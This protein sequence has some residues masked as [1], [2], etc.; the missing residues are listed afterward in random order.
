MFDFD[1]RFTKGAIAGAAQSDFN[2]KN[3]KS[4][5]LPHDWSIEDL[6]NASD[7]DEKILNLSE[8]RWKFIRGDN[9]EYKK[10]GAFEGNWDIVQVPANWQRYPLPQADPNWGWFRRSVMLSEDDRGKNFSVQLGK[11]GD[12]DELYFNGQLVGSSGQMPPD[13]VSAAKEERIYLIPPSVI[14]YNGRNVLAIRVYSKSGKGGFLKSRPVRQISGPFDSYSEGGRH[15]AFTVGGVGWYR[16]TFHVSENEMQRA[17]R[18]KF[19]GVYKDANVWINGHRLKSHYNGYTPFEYNITEWIRPGEENV[20]AVR[21]DNSGLNS[22]W[23]SGS[24]IYRHVWLI[25]SEKLYHDD[26]Y[27]LIETVKADTAGSILNFSAGIKNNS[28][29]TTLLRWRVEI[30]DANGDQVMVQEK[31]VNVFVEGPHAFS[32]KLNIDDPVLWSPS[33][34]NLYTLRSSLFFGLKPMDGFETRFGI[35]SIEYSADKGLLMNGKPVLLKGGNI[36]HDNGALGAKAFNAAE[37]R[38]IKLLKE[39]GYNAVRTVHNPPSSALLNA[40]DELGMMVMEEAFDVWRVSKLP[41]DYHKVFDENWRSDVSSMVLRDRNHPSVII[42]SIGNDIP[43]RYDPGIETMTGLLKEEIHRHDTS[44]PV[45]AG[46]GLGDKEWT[47]SDNFFSV[48]DIAGYNYLK[49]KYQADN[50]RKPQRIIVGT[51]SYP[52]QAWEYWQSTVTHPFVIGDF[53]WSAFD[54]LGESGIGLYDNSV[55]PEDIYPAT[56]AYCGDFDLSG[57]LRPQGVYRKILWSKT[58]Q[59]ALYITNPK[60]TYGDLTKVDWAWEDVVPLWTWPGYEKLFF[61]AVVYTNCEEVKLF[62]NGREI[63]TKQVSPSMKN[64]V[65]FL[66]EYNPGTIVATGINDNETKVTSTIRTAEFPKAIILKPDRNEMVADGQ[67]LVYVD[68]EIH[69][70][71]GNL[72]PNYTIPLNFKLLG[73]GEIVGIGNGNPQ[74]TESFQGPVKSTYNGRC[75]VII[76]SKQVAG[77]IQLNVADVGKLVPGSVAIKSV[78]SRK[79]SLW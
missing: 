17:F 68:V 21:V 63:A 74:N 25:K 10:Y 3:W 66:V 1:W 34:P 47:R 69:D 56:S 35:R 58:P 45:T 70:K 20:L 40:C 36:H 26:R 6:Q 73:P 46:F 5:N 37:Y 60:P 30:E 38:K 15:T 78:S 59:V 52:K 4:V 31:M 53:V 43:E 75:Q 33:N 42:W 22:R 72:N 54:Y 24:G 76:R 28:E 7:E 39:A 14:N 50:K 16:K 32:M 77:N 19:D 12:T 51:A 64:R 65:T 27:C 62:S 57:N 13:F 61:E 67:D 79:W 9:P 11:I 23:Y 71:N 55:S 2:D 8:G 41:E 49:N 29:D 48:L 18:L 44:R